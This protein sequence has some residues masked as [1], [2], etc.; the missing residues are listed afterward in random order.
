MTFDKES[1]ERAASHLF[2]HAR[3]TA[4][5]FFNTHKTAI[6][7]VSKQNIE[8]LLDETQ[9]HMAAGAWVSAFDSAQAALSAMEAYEDIEE[10]GDYGMDDPMAGDEEEWSAE[11]LSEE[12]NGFLSAITHIIQENP[13]LETDRHGAF[14]TKVRAAQQ[15]ADKAKASGDAEDLARAIGIVEGTLRELEYAEDDIKHR[16]EN[17]YDSRI[18]LIR[19]KIWQ[20]ASSDNP[21]SDEE[22]KEVF[23][24]YE[25]AEQIRAS[26]RDIAFAI[27]DKEYQQLKKRYYKAR[28]TKTPVTHSDRPSPRKTP[29][30]NAAVDRLMARLDADIESRRD[31]VLDK[32]DRAK[33]SRETL[34]PV[35]KMVEHGWRVMTQKQ[36]DA[37]LSHHNA[38]GWEHSTYIQV[39]SLSGEGEAQYF[40]KEC[41]YADLLDMSLPTDLSG[42]GSIKTYL[43]QR[44]YTRDD[45]G[46][47]RHSATLIEMEKGVVASRTSGEKVKSAW[48]ISSWK[49]QTD[50]DLKRLY[51]SGW[52]QTNGATA[53]SLLKNAHIAD[54]TPRFLTVLRMTKAQPTHEYFVKYTTTKP[55]EPP[56]PLEGECETLQYYISPERIIDN[57]EEKVTGTLFSVD[58]NEAREKMEHPAYA[59]F[60]RDGWHIL[61]PDVVRSW[62]TENTSSQPARFFSLAEIPT[63]RGGVFVGKTSN[64]F[65]PQ[66]PTGTP[67]HH[68]RTINIT[69]YQNMGTYI[70]D[71]AFHTQLRPI[72]LTDG[73]FEPIVENEEGLDNELKQRALRLEQRMSQTS[74]MHSPELMSGVGWHRI[75][76]DT[77]K[78]WLSLGSTGLSIDASSVTIAAVSVTSHHTDD[79][80][81]FCSFD[82]PQTPVL[83]PSVDAVVT[84]YELTPAGDRLILHDAQSLHVTKHDTVPLDTPDSFTHTTA[85]FD[86][87]NTPPRGVRAVE[88]SEWS[89]LIAGY[90]SRVATLPDPES[91]NFYIELNKRYVETGPNSANA[92]IESFFQ[93]DHTIDAQTDE[94]VR[95]MMAMTSHEPRILWPAPLVVRMHKLIEA[96]RAIFSDFGTAEY[97]SPAHMGPAHTGD[98]VIT[99]GSERKA[100]P[101]EPPKTDPLAETV[102]EAAHFTHADALAETRHAARPIEPT[103]VSR[104]QSE[105]LP[106]PLQG[107]LTKE[108]MEGLPTFIQQFLLDLNTQYKQHGNHVATIWIREICDVKKGFA[109]AL[110]RSDHFIEI[111]ADLARS[112]GVTWPISIQKAIRK[113]NRLSDRRKRKQ[114]RLEGVQQ[115]QRLAAPEKGRLRR[116]PSRLA[117]AAAAGVLV[118]QTAMYAVGGWLGLTRDTRGDAE[119]GARH[120]ILEPHVP[121]MRAADAGPPLP[122][123][124]SQVDAAK[125]DTGSFQPD[126]GPP[127]SDAHATGSVADQSRDAAQ[128]AFTREQSEGAQADAPTY[129]TPEAKQDAGT[130]EEVIQKGAGIISTLLK[131]L[132]RAGIDRQTARGMMREQYRRSLATPGQSWNDIKVHPEDK[133]LFTLEKR[134]GKDVLTS[135]TITHKTNLDRLEE[136]AGEQLSSGTHETDVEHP[137]V[138]VDDTFQIDEITYTVGQTVTYRTLAGKT[139]RFIIV[140]P[141]KS[142]KK[143]GVILRHENSN[144]QFETGSHLNLIAPVEEL[145][146]TRSYQGVRVSQ[147]GENAYRGQFIKGVGF[148]T[149]LLTLA[150]QHFHLDRPTALLVMRIAD[151]K[152]KTNGVPGE[153]DM[154]YKGFPSAVH[155]GDWF[156]FDVSGS[157]NNPRITVTYIHKKHPHVLEF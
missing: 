76:E 62:Q 156:D 59:L 48:R 32:E 50:R 88:F 126:A 103:E 145:Q 24:K 55:A 33:K 153:E 5:R 96:D 112:Y 138:H 29:E 85:S 81:L 23:Q 111:A 84:R 77:L 51:E 11:Q 52:V 108:R 14:E 155:D 144:R 78:L 132:Q 101:V 7:A 125:Q 118:F 42:Q 110:S 90:E 65:P 46:R 102:D 121:A 40:F 104:K 152:A 1:L 34:S 27:L 66:L 150:M 49:E 15:V 28:R 109:R 44:V 107:V 64:L 30:G 58:S 151:A 94:H 26:D 12:L 134:D 80:M 53:T 137:P 114:E 43:R 157:K 136:R 57:H 37:I 38:S 13:S 47:D 54:T 100:E 93:D 2:E 10:E 115:L 71:R 60:A 36:A 99:D 35:E 91:R 106:G 149:A 39:A 146:K 72:E 17:L 56:A 117:R 95:L 133:V 31:A 131:G 113:H 86:R 116:P 89:S 19:E 119:D 41:T 63:D 45:Q 135:V 129:T 141:S 127:P 148:Q 105:P 97:T 61:S 4:E 130:M 6:D 92:F 21:L 9:K 123:P 142:M 128:K 18:K 16:K 87:L 139:K 143:P 75:T 79:R 8:H 3:D 69:H 122:V 22:Y 154:R 68:A 70:G 20:L 83:P 147:T 67:E 82:H 98:I 120:A 25:M 124:D 140:G 74:N 73:R